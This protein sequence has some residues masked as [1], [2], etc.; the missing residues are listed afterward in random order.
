M[1]E[2]SQLNCCEQVEPKMQKYETSRNKDTQGTDG[3][4]S[5][6]RKLSTTRQ[7]RLG[8]TDT[9][10]PLLLLPPICAQPLTLLDDRSPRRSSNET[11]GNACKA[12]VYLL[13][14]NT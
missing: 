6:K 13:D 9:H 11:H 8:S 12:T 5:T 1:L 10:G 2:V 4:M 3:A 7:Y 14:T